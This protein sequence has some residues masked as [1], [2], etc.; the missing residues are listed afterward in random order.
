[1]I[2]A[3]IRNVLECSVDVI[4]C[5]G[6][7]AVSLTL[8]PLRQD[9]NHLTKFQIPNLSGSDLKIKS[10]I[11]HKDKYANALAWDAPS[12][13]GGTA[14][15]HSP[16]TGQHRPGA[17]SDIYDCLAWAQF[18]KYLTISH[19]FVVRSTCDSDFRCNKISS[20]N[21]VSRFTSTISCSG[22][23]GSRVVSV[24]D[25]DG[26]KSHRDAVG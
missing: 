1:M 3:C 16:T 14:I 12:W 17:K 2:R 18:T 25:S 22:W 23:L 8:Q 24:L 6:P 4:A 20:G 7:V 10:Q 21:V 15:L 9:L 5:Q 26:F 19:K 13:D 11:F